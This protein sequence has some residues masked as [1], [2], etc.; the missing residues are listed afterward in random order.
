MSLMC[1]VK[2]FLW[3]R[4]LGSL[5]LAILLFIAAGYLACGTGLSD[6]SSRWDFREC[7]GAI[8][9]P[10]AFIPDRFEQTRGGFFVID[11]LLVV[12]PLQL[13]YSY[14]LL[15]FNAIAIGSG[16]ADKIRQIFGAK[17]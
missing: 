10:A 16:M 4:L 8:L 14:A 15:T 9:L 7:L 1:G 13:L 12:F 11:E 3:K 6:G 17:G 5:P 2:F